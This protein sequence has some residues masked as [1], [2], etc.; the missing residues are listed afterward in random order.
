MKTTLN[1]LQEMQI[2]VQVVDAGSFTAAGRR[3]ELPKSSVSRRVTA[4][5]QRLGVRLLHRTTRSLRLTA[6]GEAYYEKA[7]KLLCELIDLESMVSGHS[8]LPVG[9]LKVSCPSGFVEL[10]SGFFAQFVRS[11][12]RVRLRIEES[13]RYVDLV[14][15]G[16]DLAF[17]GGKA[18]NPSLS[19]QSLLT[20][21]NIIVGAGSY[22]KQ[23]GAPQ[24]VKDL[25]S[26]QLILLSKSSR[27]VWDLEGPRQ[28]CQQE[29]TGRV[30]VNNLRSVLQLVSEGLGLGLLPMQSCCQALQ[31]GRLERVL[32]EWA[33]RTS[34]LWIVYPSEREMASA[35]RAFLELARGWSFEIL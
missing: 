10:N 6:V 24:Q 12:P 3:L 32:S 34:E 31:E 4:L 7:S 15:E 18:P 17:R 14:T 35:V 20:T 33:G 19:G 25:A 21:P 26:H 11:H 29:L 1:S 27:A 13:D 16:F 22:L 28:A 9:S 30:C 5:E 2:L 8:E 23:S